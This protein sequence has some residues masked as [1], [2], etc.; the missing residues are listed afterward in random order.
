MRC[1]FACCSHEILAYPHDNFIVNERQ[2]HNTSCNVTKWMFTKTEDQLN[3]FM[4]AFDNRYGT[5]YVSCK[6]LIT[7]FLFVLHGLK[8]RFYPNRSEHVCAHI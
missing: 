2:S 4:W 6:C 3:A 5:H 7:F 1:I 8:C